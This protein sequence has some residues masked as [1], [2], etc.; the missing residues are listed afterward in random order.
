MKT[1]EQ[2]ADKIFKLNNDL[3]HFIE[4][5][6]QI[7]QAFQNFK[8]TP[9]PE[10]TFYDFFFDETFDSG[11]KLIDIYIDKNPG[12]TDEEKSELNELKNTINSVFEV[13]NIYKEGFDL[14]NLVSEK[15]Y[16]VK[17]LIKMVNY[18]GVSR[19]NFL[20]CRV[21]PFK[22]E[23]FLFSVNSVIKST[24]SINAYRLAVS[25]QMKDPSLLYRDN[26]HKFAEIEKNVSF[27]AQKFEKFFNNQEIITLNTKINALL[28]A[29]ND[30]VDDEGLK[31]DFEELTE[32][33]ENYEY[34]DLNKKENNQKTYDVGVMFDPDSGL[35]TIPFF[36]TFCKIFEVEDYKSVKD[37]RDCVKSFLNDER[38]P[39]F[40]L[41][42]AHDRFGDSFLQR[43][44]KIL[45]IKE[46]IDFENLLH[47]YKYKFL[48]DKSFSSPTVLYSSE[49]F[50]NLMKL[51]SGSGKK[52]TKK[53][54]GIGRNDPCTCG[55]GKKY[56]KCC[57]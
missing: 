28:D 53:S 40:V 18:R 30:Y 3:N 37:Y 52:A 6:K 15:S 57:M 17:S 32:L 42:K 34:F 33:P 44:R 21:I 9:A 19:G 22:G 16:N 25:S 31:T 43:V 7:S 20:I 36:G 5:D 8:N 50:E 55:S 4:S 27:L 29:F 13:K 1:L 45:R 49:A 12:L 14:Y 23:F 47:D 10:K 11:K 54:P 26:E 51:S 24:D 2:K 41:K 56:K 35:L 39:P 46:E 38:I 48:S